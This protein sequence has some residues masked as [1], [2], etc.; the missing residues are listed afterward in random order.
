MFK[1]LVKL[2]GNNVL[3]NGWGRLGKPSHDIKPKNK[4]PRQAGAFRK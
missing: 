3:H 1:E 4:R 2:N